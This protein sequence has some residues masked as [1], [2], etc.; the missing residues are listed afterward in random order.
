MN[1]GLHVVG[2][3]NDLLTFLMDRNSSW[4]K[5]PL[6]FKSL[7]TVNICRSISAE[8]ESSVAR[9]TKRTISAI[10]M[11]TDNLHNCKNQSGFTPDRKRHGSPAGSL[12]VSVRL[13]TGTSSL[14]PVQV[15]SWGSLMNEVVCLLERTLAVN[16]YTAKTTSLPAA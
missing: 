15:C 14:R 11:I 9:V 12:T 2:Q 13:S 6:R 4:H 3:P 5:S 10:P 8:S 16:A 7:I 1:P